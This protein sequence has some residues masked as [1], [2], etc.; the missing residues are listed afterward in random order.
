MGLFS[1]KDKG[2]KR[3]GGK[4]VVTGKRIKGTWMMESSIAPNT[5]RGK[6]N[7]VILDTENRRLRTLH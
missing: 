3:S 5:R 7:D 4:V 2:S 1:K 6:R